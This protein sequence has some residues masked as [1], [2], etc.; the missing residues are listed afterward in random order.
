M[1]VASSV[2]PGEVPPVVQGEEREE[3]GVGHDVAVVYKPRNAPPGLEW[4]SHAA[5]NGFRDEA[6]V[7]GEE[8]REL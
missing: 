8:C 7:D 2:D 5:N 3:V 4:E 1:P 6:R